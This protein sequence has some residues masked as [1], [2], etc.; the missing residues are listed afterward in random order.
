MQTFSNAINMVDCCCIPISELLEDQVNRTF[1]SSTHETY[2]TQVYV[3][4]LIVECN[5]TFDAS[6]KTKGLSTD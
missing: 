6:L 2:Y 5:N 4:F 1:A 3:S